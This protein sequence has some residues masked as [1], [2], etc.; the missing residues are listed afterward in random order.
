MK[1]IFSLIGIFIFLNTLRADNI[2]FTA[3]GPRVVEVGEQFEITF[4][5]NAQPSGFR[6]PEFKG[7]SLIGGPS[8][9]SSTSIQ[10]INGRVTQNVTFSYSYYF[11]ATKAGTYTIDPAKA[12]VDGKSYLSNSLTIEVVASGK[13]AAGIPGSASTQSGNEGTSAGNQDEVVAEAGNDDLFVRILVDK[14]T[15]YQG[16]KIIATIKLYSRLNISSIEKVDYPSFNGFFRQDIETPPLQHLEREVINGQVY[17]T[18]ILQR[19][20]LIPQNAGQVTIEPFSLQAVVQVPVS[21]RPRSIWDDFWGPQVREIRKKISS[22]PVKITVKALPGNA[23]QSFKGAVGN[24]TFNVSLD[25]QNV[26]TNDAINL[27]ITISGNGNLKIIQPFDIKFPTDFETYD[28]KVTVNTKA[29]LNGIEGS[30]SF[31]YLIIPR[32]SGTFKIAP[33]EFT[34]FDLQSKQY[35]TASSGELVINVEK[36]ADEGKTTIVQGVDREDVKFL[37][38]DIQFI[39]TKNLNLNR[40]DEFL[41]AQPLFGAMYAISLMLFGLFVWFMRNQI[42]ANADVAGVRLRKANKIAIRRLQIA[43]ENLEAQLEEKFYENVLKALWGYVSDKFNIP[44]ADLSRE[45]VYELAALHNI[46]NEIVDE[47]MK[48]LDHCEFARYAP[49]QGSGH[50]QDVYQN[51]IQVISKF[52]QNFKK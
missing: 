52:E 15:A 7:F 17:G 51:A 24:Y 11:T 22:K 13:A 47:L 39:K 49:A 26:K 30:K 41:I 21:R 50:M 27:K 2:Q 23:P 10:Y 43:K 12:T 16:E 29:T 14:T 4:T 38:K 32:H 25:K 9:S 36:S 46:S 34:W 31:E 3:S 28:P 1:Y 8:Q 40:K 6:P 18:G 44:L 37:G 45:K 20:V 35:K 42:R 19:M 33:I 48:L 5:I